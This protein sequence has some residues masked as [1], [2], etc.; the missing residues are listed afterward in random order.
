M[1]NIELIDNQIAEFEQMAELGHE[2]ADETGDGSWRDLARQ[3]E[4]KARQW[5]ELRD[6]LADMLS[7][8]VETNVELRIQCH[9][10]H[11]EVEALKAG[12]EAECERLRKIHADTV[13]RLN[14]QIASW[15][16][17]VTNLTIE[18]DA[19]AAELQ[20]LKARMAE[21][22][23]YQYQ[24]RD[25]EWCSFI[26][27]R[28][29]ENTVADGTWPIRAIYAAP[30]AAQEV[31][32]ALSTGEWRLTKMPHCSLLTEEALAA[33]AW[34]VERQAAPFCGDDGVRHWFAPSAVE[35]LRAGKAA[36]A[37]HR[38]AQQQ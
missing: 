37:A 31:M 4:A 14:G 7:G 28:H 6:S 30:P 9:Q 13:D 36:I 1:K 12:L 11:E 35:A 24:S 34:M 20:A 26:D 25:G 29:Y 2:Y 16:G 17:E 15:S 21:P 32:D 22:V 5:R 10:L 33:R 8:E 23:G 27:Q 19:L 3:C 18:R 38:Q